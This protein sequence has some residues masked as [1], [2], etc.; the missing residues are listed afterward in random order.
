MTL[1]WDL[2]AQPV[3]ASRY[4]LGHLSL[5]EDW[6]EKWRIRVNAVGQSV[7][8]ERLATLLRTERALIRKALGLSSVKGEM[9]R[10]NRK[11]KKISPV[12]PT[13][14]SANRARLGRTSAWNALNP[15]REEKFRLVDDPPLFMVSI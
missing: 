12:T 14:Q 1:Q 13:G 3:E 11:R 2:P 15:E 7:P 4:I 9:H 8:R 5:L 10:S 6:F